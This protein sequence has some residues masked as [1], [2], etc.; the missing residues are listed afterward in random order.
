MSPCGAGQVGS[1]GSVSHQESFLPLNTGSRGPLPSH[2]V[3]AMR[4]S[5]TASDHVVCLEGSFHCI[6]RRRYGCSPDGQP[7]RSGALPGVAT[8]CRTRSARPKGTCRRLM[9][10]PATTL[11]ARCRESCRS[12]PVSRAPPPRVV[13][14]MTG[15]GEAAKWHE[16]IL[17]GC[18]NALPRRRCDPFEIS[19]SCDSS[20]SKPMCDL[21]HVTHARSCR[22]ALSPFPF[23]ACAFHFALL[24]PPIP[25][26]RALRS[27]SSSSRSSSA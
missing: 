18:S 13:L 12:A 7:H 10:A 19:F 20:R 14:R 22:A 24:C 4:S 15:Y 25:P 17:S 3:V 21:R 5:I 1:F 16:R 23:L 11:R 26:N 27:A 9:V 8:G 2:Q 6:V